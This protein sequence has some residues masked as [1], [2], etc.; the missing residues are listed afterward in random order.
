[1]RQIGSQSFGGTDLEG[2]ALTAT[3][4]L[5]FGFIFDLG[6]LGGVFL[7]SGLDLFRCFLDG[8]FVV[9][10]TTARHSEPP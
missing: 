8:L 6:R 7:R 2:S 1:L 10:T 5:L 4:T 3:T 9:V